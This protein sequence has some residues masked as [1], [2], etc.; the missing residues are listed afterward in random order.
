[1]ADSMEPGELVCHVQNLSYTYDT[2]F[3]CMGLGPSISSVIAKSLSYSGPSYPSSPVIIG[4]SLPIHSFIHL[5]F[6]LSDHSCPLLPSS[7]LVTSSLSGP[8]PRDAWRCCS[9]SSWWSS[10]YRCR[11]SPRCSTGTGHTGYS[12]H[13]EPTSKQTFLRTFEHT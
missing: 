6:Y 13:A 8:G 5:R 7:R 10:G 4:L 11:W 1:M 9:S 12:L 2:Y 3:I